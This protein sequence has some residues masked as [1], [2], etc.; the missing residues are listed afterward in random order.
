MAFG[1]DGIFAVVDYS[2]TFT[3][4]CQCLELFRKYKLAKGHSSMS[5]YTM[6]T[7][8]F[9]ERNF[10]TNIFAR[11]LA[12]LVENGIYGRWGRNVKIER[13]QM[14]YYVQF[15]EEDV[16]RNKSVGANSAE[17]TTLDQVRVVFVLWFGL[18]VAAAA[19]FMVEC[20]VKTLFG[21]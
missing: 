14:E 10:F 21:I 4:F 7:F 20:K 17:A 16:G 18:S 9:V 13:R 3:R 8:W 19:I 5:F 11:G 2:D 1:N 15:R 12:S 6:Q